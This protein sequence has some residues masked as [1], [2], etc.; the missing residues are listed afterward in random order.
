M[1]RVPSRLLQRVAL[2]VSTAVI[3]PFGSVGAQGLVVTARMNPRPLTHP[4]A[5]SG[6][7]MVIVRF[8]G[9]PEIGL[10]AIAL[11]PIVLVDGLGRSY[12]PVAYVGGVGGTQPRDVFAAYTSA[13]AE[14]FRDRQYIYFVSPGL[15]TFEIRIAGLKPVRITPTL[16]TP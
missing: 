3:I 7:F 11:N 6:K 9:M 16:T 2:V 12:T 5:D 14:R 8:N 13:N 4:G 15:M 1:F 10:R